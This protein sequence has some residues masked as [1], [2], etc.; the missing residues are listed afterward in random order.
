MVTGLTTCGRC[1]V[2][3]EPDDDFC[4]ECGFHLAASRKPKLQ[5][6]AAL[7]AVLT[8]L[9]CGAQHEDSTQFCESCGSRMSDMGVY[10]TTV[11]AVRLDP[12]GEH[13]SSAAVRLAASMRPPSGAANRPADA[14]NWQPPGPNI[15]PAVEARVAMTSAR[16]QSY[17][18]P[19]RQGRTM[20]GAAWQ[21]SNIVRGAL[22]RFRR[23]VSVNNLRR[24]A[25]L[26]FLSRSTLDFATGLVL[27][28]FCGTVAW[29]IVDLER[30][31][32]P[33]TNIGLVQAQ[34]ALKAGRLDESLA[35]MEKLSIARDGTLSS[36][37]KTVRNQAFYKRAKAW[38][39]KG[40]YQ[41]AIADLLRISP[42]FP[43]YAESRQKVAEFAKLGDAK[44]GRKDSKAKRA[45]V[46][47]SRATET[48]AASSSSAAKNGTTVASKEVRPA[49][50]QASQ[51]LDNTADADSSQ[52]IHYTDADQVR[53]HKLLEGYFSASRTAASQSPEWI[54]A[55]QSPS[56]SA[57]KA[58]P[59]TLQEWL[60]QGKPDF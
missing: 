4:Q 30:R 19:R 8:C 56:A 40:D 5:P 21:A 23:I 46:S 35:I 17:T 50:D 20:P 11:R 41:S 51:D 18:Q 48:A 13:H 3:V 2:P 36:E 39:D 52:R 15:H 16:W 10:T 24:A 22:P 58:E 12:S 34:A 59:P 7:K 53:Y 44:P 57:E 25:L 32:S 42:D 27:L 9:N 14:I 60:K 31:Q 29:S 28:V 33:A 6:P 55:D 38:A 45:A 49:A 43:E 37:E 26:P 1:R 47:A 54:S